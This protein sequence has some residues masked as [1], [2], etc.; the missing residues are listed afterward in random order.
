MITIIDILATQYTT[1]TTNHVRAE[2]IGDTTADLPAATGIT[3]YTLLQGSTCIIIQDSAL[4][5]MQSNGTWIQ[6]IQDI[7][8][9]TYTRQQID[10]F[11]AEKQNTLTFDTT[12]TDGSTNP[13]TSGGIYTAFSTFELPKTLAFNG[14][15]HQAQPGWWSRVTNLQY[16]TDTPSDYS[17]GFQIHVLDTGIG[18][19]HRKKIFFYPLTAGYEGTFYIQQELAP[20]Q[21]SPVWSPWYK[22]T[23]S[24]V[25]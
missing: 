16:V 13:V 10:S 1:D 24:Q 23:G 22:F 17:G 20:V 21:Q 9:D 12:P 3:G 18:S 5:R 4:Y 15:I 25:Q 19:P 7:T 11:L 8:A 2:L 14:S 6:Q